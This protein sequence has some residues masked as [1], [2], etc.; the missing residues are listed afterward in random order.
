MKAAWRDKYTRCEDLTIHEIERPSP[1]SDQIL[2]KVYATTVNRTDVA[3]ATGNPFIMRFFTGL[4]KPKIKVVGTD[5]AGEIVA[6]GSDVKEFKVGDRVMGFRDEGLGSQAEYAAISTKRAILT[7]PDQLDYVEAAACQEASHYAYSWIHGRQLGKSH[8]V[9]INGVTGAIGT[10]LIQ[11]LKALE[12][13]VTAVG[14]T[15]NIDLIKKL[16]ANK[17]YN[18]EKEDFTLCNLKYDYIFDAVGKSTYGKCKPLLKEKGIYLSS[19]LGPW[20]QN[21]FL[22]LWT[23]KSKG[24]K[25]EFPV[26]ADILRSMKYVKQQVE[27]EQYKPVIEKAYPLDQIAEAYS[28]VAGGNKTGHVVLTING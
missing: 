11:Y 15:K 14:N 9:L 10:A 6:L 24:K 2:V 17:I 18:Y 20:G 12:V 28:Y 1:K 5:F 7:I 26:P 16:G 19:E 8:T 13:E 23:A 3:V 25:V 27:K 22:A 4:M 21:P